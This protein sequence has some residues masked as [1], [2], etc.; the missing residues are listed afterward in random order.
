MAAGS[1]VPN[2]S[3]KG[4]RVRRRWGQAVDI[5]AVHA[6]R[7]ADAHVAPRGQLT[8]RFERAAKIFN[9][10]PQTLYTVDAKML[11]D[12][13]HAL[14]NRYLAKDKRNASQT[15]VEEHDTELDLLLRDVVAAAVDELAQERGGVEHGAAAGAEKDV[16]AVIGLWQ[17]VGHTPLNEVAAMVMALDEGFNL[18]QLIDPESYRSDQFTDALVALHQLWLKD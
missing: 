14:K 16:A 4:K 8:E 13:F 5:V 2:F 12:H 11:K 7:A 18:H 17:P 1:E 10:H 6:A 15:G 3:T 9:A